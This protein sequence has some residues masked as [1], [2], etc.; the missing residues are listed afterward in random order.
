V[1]LPDNTSVCRPPAATAVI[2]TPALNVT[3]HGGA[4]RVSSPEVELSGPCFAD[5]NLL[6]FVFSFPALLLS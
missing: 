1:E 5:D 3:R 2:L 4:D 6:R